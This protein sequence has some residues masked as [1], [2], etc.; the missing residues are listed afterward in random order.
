MKP[1]C[2]QDAWLQKKFKH[3]EEYSADDANDRDVR[4]EKKLWKQSRNRLMRRAGKQEM[5]DGFGD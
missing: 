5:K 1:V 4:K 3:P 2:K